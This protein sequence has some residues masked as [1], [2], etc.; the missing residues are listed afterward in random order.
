MMISTER[1]LLRQW[2]DDDFEAFYQINKDPEVM[3]YY[4]STMNRQESDNM[5]RRIQS[6]I[7]ERDWGFWALELK[8]N[9]QFIGFTGLHIPKANLPCSPCVEIGWRVAK[10]YWNRGY[11]TE[12]ARASLDYAFDHLILDDVVSFTAN[13]NK[14]SQAV[15]KK[16]GM[17]DTRE[18]FLHPDV[19]SGHEL[20]EHVLYRITRDQWKTR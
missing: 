4:P 8:E 13:I 14:P 17:A 1:L 10:T 20:S 11:A 9:Q 18:N 3:R 6:L 15:M 5:A 7:E 2:T 19:P 12:A 16:L